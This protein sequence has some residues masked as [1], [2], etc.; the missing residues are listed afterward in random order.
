[1]KT[2]I[3]ARGVSAACKYGDELSAVK[4]ISGIVTALVIF[5]ALGL[6]YFTG[7]TWPFTVFLFFVLIV[8]QWELYAMS[9]SRGMHPLRVLGLLLGV[10]FLAFAFTGMYV[11]AS[12]STGGSPP[13]AWLAGDVQLNY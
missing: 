12:L 3:N 6:D 11:A 9:V 13:L 5:V 10:V 8:A 2:S 7:T 1:L 4:I